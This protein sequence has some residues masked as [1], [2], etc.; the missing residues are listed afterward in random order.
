MFHNIKFCLFS[1]VMLVAFTACEKEQSVEN[2]DI[3][4]TGGTQ[5]GT[6]EYTLDGSPLACIAPLISG[7]YVVGTA[8]DP[9]NSVAIT[10]NVTGVGTYV[11][12]TGT[13][14]GISFTGSGTFPGTGP[15]TITLFGSG[16][17][18][19]ANSSTYTPGT[20][21]CS[22]VITA[23]TSVVTPV[24]DSLYYSATIDG[25]FYH[26][27]VPA[28]GYSAGFSVNGLDDVTLGSDITPVV[29]PRPL[30]T[31]SFALNKGILHSYIATTNATFKA[32]FT[33][34]TYLFAPDNTE[35]VTI[36]WGDPTGTDW[37]TDNAPGT[38]TG[39]AFN[40]VSV[41]DEPG[42]PDYTVR[43]T[44]TFNCKLYDAAGNSKTLT[45]GKYVG[46]FAKF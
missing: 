37:S 10:V 30:N 44:A 45:N 6:A 41:A 16:T 32:F 3:F 22:F 17:P 8:L 34:N 4:N 18:V 36:F 12:S 14:N 7:D 33:P 15:Q 21:G 38:Q 39:S 23:T 43:V 13:I 46:L 40:I 19:A 5:S 11:I 26:Q 1:I 25:V 42:Q 9:S 35:G 20:S 27:A 29:D 31:T 2:G 24:T 28:T